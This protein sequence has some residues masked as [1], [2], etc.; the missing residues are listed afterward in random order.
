MNRIRTAVR[1]LLAPAL[2]AASFTV[3]VS[4]VVSAQDTEEIRARMEYDRLR[5]YSGGP[6]NRSRSYEQRP[7]ESVRA[8]VIGLVP[9]P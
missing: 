3:V 8:S 5:L 7:A 4:T 1:C 2:A 9:A 6:A